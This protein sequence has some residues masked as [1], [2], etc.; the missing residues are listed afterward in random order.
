MKSFPNHVRAI[1]T[2][3]L[4]NG[5]I[6]FMAG[7][8]NDP[9]NF[10]MN[11]FTSTVWDPR[12]N[13]WTDIPTPDDVFCSGHVQLPNG[14]VLIMGGTKDFPAADG[15]HGYEG[16]KASWI[17]NITSNTYQQVNDMNTGHWY[18]SATELGNGNIFSMGG[19]NENGDGTVTNEQFD[20][21]SST[22]QPYTDFPQQFTYFGLYPANIL[23]QDGKL[24]YTG[25]PRV[26]RLAA[27]HPVRRHHDRPDQQHA[28]RRAGPAEHRRA[29]P[30]RRGAAAPGAEPEGDGARRRQRGHQRRRQ[31][32][33]RPDR[34]EGGQ[35]VLHAR[36]AAAAGPDRD[37]ARWPTCR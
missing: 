6:L 1:H 23:T 4:S 20:T 5:K 18:P 13:T 27:A 33:H 30:V 9:T 2:V 34:P 26:R 24:F 16:L 14:N 7:S 19:L 17:F 28:D 22:W 15:S 29:R 3:V 8:G 25:S 21:A 35:P 31:P 10:A 32:A 37:P 36:P 12:S 11:N